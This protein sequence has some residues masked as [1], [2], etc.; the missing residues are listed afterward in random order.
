MWVSAMHPVNY[1]ASLAIYVIKSSVVCFAGEKTVTLRN[2]MPFSESHE[3]KGLNEQ[4]V[5]GHP[6]LDQC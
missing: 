6:F 3:V 5:Q 1:L 2:S 4:S